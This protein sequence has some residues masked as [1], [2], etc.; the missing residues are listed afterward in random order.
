MA[1]RASVQSVVP[2]WGLICST[3]ERSVIGFDGCTRR[4]DARAL[5]PNGYQTQAWLQVARRFA[6]R[7]RMRALRRDPAASPRC[8]SGSSRWP[9]LF[10][11]FD[12]LHGERHRGLTAGAPHDL[13]HGASRAFDQA[14][15]KGNPLLSTA[16]ARIRDRFVDAAL[17]CGDLHGG[18][19][20]WWLEQGMSAAR[21]VHRAGVSSWA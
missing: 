6:P 12:S 20:W 8:Q 7:S 3:G 14:G 1:L 11:R 19:T 15:T 16:A 10:G 18:L 4:S 17:A 9:S 13:R 5:M 21:H 2:G